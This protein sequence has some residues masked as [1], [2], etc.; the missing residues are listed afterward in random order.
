MVDTKMNEEYYPAKDTPHGYTANPK[1]RIIRILG[2]W[3][4]N[5]RVSI[6]YQT[7]LGMLEVNICGWCKYFF[8]RPKMWLSN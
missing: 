4:G 3:I 1:Y 7:Q 2:I 5:K 6:N 8:I